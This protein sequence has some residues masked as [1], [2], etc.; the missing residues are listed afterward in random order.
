MIL[1]DDSMWQH[2]RYQEEALR[3]HIGHC[4][5]QLECLPYRG[6][7][8]LYASGSS[9]PCQAHGGAKRFTVVMRGS[10]GVRNG[11]LL[12]LCNEQMD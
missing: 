4:G 12:L 9:Q 3:L 2:E 11:A 10:G 5:E 8:D 1:R 7:V 6:H